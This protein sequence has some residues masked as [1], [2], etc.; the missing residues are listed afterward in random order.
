MNKAG[1]C[2]RDS[3]M[4]PISCKPAKVN[5]HTASQGRDHNVAAGW[6]KVAVCSRARTC[7]CHRPAA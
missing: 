4:T 1:N 7:A 6:R 5:L 3:E 2:A